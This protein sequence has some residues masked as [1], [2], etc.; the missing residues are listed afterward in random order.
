MEKNSNKTS[1]S[2]EAIKTR[3]LGTDL[4]PSRAILKEN[5]DGVFDALNKAG[6]DQLS[7]LKAV[8]QTPAKLQ[9]LSQQCGVS[10]D[11][12]N[13]LRREI[14]S[15]ESKP[16]K[17]KDIA[18]LTEEEIQL[19]QRLK[20]H[21]SNDLFQEVKSRGGVTFLQ[22]N[23][24][25]SEKRLTYLFQLSDLVRVQWV[26]LNF[27]MWLIEAGYTCVQDV[28]R[29]NADEMDARLR[30]VNLNGKFFKGSI[31]QRDLNRLIYSA[32][33]VD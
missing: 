21:S 22:Q 33:F 31:G 29:A 11:Y 32:K 4:V 9:A 28:A 19:I 6:I 25:I 30:A 16:F 14:E 13:L 12:L 17:I 8:L 24:G 1:M 3:I 7:E 20:I 15:Y 10:V 5:I 27:A 2:L 23:T 26:S 18:V